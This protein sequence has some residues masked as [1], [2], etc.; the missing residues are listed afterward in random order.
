VNL[1]EV[2]AVNTY[3]GESHILFDVSLHVEEG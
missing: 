3:Y 2:E 1:L